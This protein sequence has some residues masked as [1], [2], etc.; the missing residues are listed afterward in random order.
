MLTITCTRAAKSVAR[1]L[2][3]FLLPLMRGVR[4]Q[5]HEPE[6]PDHLVVRRQRNIGDFTR[7]KDHDAYSNAFERLL[8]DLKAG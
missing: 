7:W 4:R 5:G 8:R 1:S 2:L 6:K 3:S